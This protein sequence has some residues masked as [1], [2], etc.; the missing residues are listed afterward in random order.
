MEITIVKFQTIV[1]TIVLTVGLAIMIN[2]SKYISLEPPIFPFFDEQIMVFKDKRFEEAIYTQNKIRY[3]LTYGVASKVTSL[4]LQSNEITDVNELIYFM[5]LEMLDV[6]NNLLNKLDISQNKKLI[7][8]Y[9]DNNH[10][11]SLDVSNNLYLHTLYCNDNHLTSLDV[12]NNVYLQTLYCRKNKI[13]FLNVEQLVNLKTVFCDFNN[14]KEMKLPNNTEKQLTYLGCSNNYLRGTLDLTEFHKIAGLYLHNNYFED[15][16]IN[17]VNNVTS[18]SYSPHNVS[19]HSLYY[20]QNILGTNNTV[21]Y[22][23]Y[24]YYYEEYVNVWV[25]K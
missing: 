15:I 16:V 22:L 18:L 2:Y 3:P 19:A 7:A 11:T 9:C 25:D 10:L 12:S 4:W 20:W 5:N 6:S 24:D 23:V 13:E 21:Y 8:L 14:L 17:S 1:L